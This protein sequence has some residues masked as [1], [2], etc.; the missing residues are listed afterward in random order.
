MKTR[1]PA[2]E[3]RFYPAGSHRILEQIRDIEHQARYP[4]LQSPPSSIYGAVL[5]HAGHI[6]S[7]HQTVPFFNLIRKLGLYPESFVIVHPDHRGAGKPLAIE[8]S[9]RWHNSIG[10]VYIDGEFAVAMELPFETKAYGSEHSAEVI[11]PY[12]QYY[13]GDRP[14]HIVPVCMGDQTYRIARHTGE[15]IYQGACRTGRN[16]MVL[17]SSDFSHFLSP[18][19]GRMK[20]QH[21]LDPIIGR[22]TEG[23]ERSVQAHRVSVCGFGPI[24]ALMEYSRM[25]DP[26]YRVEILARGNS[27]EV[28][29]SLEVVDYISL[30]TCR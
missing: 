14:F 2:V 1:Y 20:D 28:H 22:D 17:S 18:E 10:D 6:Y 8:G 29:P 16:I 12:L 3:G 26:D 9:D 11:I 23:V 19:E 27:G 15:M 25:V 24:M 13:M 21:V 4:E 7:G 5:P 30:I